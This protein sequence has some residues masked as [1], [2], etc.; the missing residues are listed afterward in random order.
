MEAKEFREDGGGVGRLE[1]GLYVREKYSKSKSSSSMP[2]GESTLK[3]RGAIVDV[4]YIINLPRRNLYQIY[5]CERDVERRHEAEE[6]KLMTVPEVLL[7]SPFYC[8]GRGA[9]LSGTRDSPPGPLH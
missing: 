2:P 1:S 4:T 5:E 8:R 6:T 7:G 9:K 3:L